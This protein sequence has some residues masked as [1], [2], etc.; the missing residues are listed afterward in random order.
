MKNKLK[1]KKKKKK[2]IKRKENLLLDLIALEGNKRLNED[3][4]QKLLLK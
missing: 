3:I 1:K 2:K 4:F